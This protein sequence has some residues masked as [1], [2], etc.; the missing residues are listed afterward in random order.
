MYVVCAVACYMIHDSFSVPLK[1]SKHLYL[2]HIAGDILQRYKHG[3][4]LTSQVS[5]LCF[6]WFS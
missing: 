3:Q 4:W 6:V 1:D 2:R 5:H